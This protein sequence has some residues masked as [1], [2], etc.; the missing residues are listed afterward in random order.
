MNR[1]TSSICMPL[2]KARARV[3]PTIGRCACAG[4][5]VIVRRQQGISRD[6]SWRKKAFDHTTLN[7][8][9]PIPK[10]TSYQ[11]RHY[12]ITSHRRSNTF[13]ALHHADCSSSHLCQ[14]LPPKRSLQTK[15]C[16]L[17]QE[18][19]VTNI[20]PLRTVAMSNAPTLI[21][22]PPPPSDPVTPS[23]IP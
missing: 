8:L 14:R 3:N 13:H 5:H 20:N 22:L 7:H 6:N 19:F 2:V 21:N 11:H 16:E 12:L 1:I 10:T 18:P 4:T 23:D 17:H 9:P 15:S